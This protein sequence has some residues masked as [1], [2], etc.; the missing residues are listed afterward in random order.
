MNGFKCKITGDVG[1][2][3]LGKPA[4]PRRYVPDPL[5]SHSL[6]IILGRCGTDPHQEG[7]DIAHPGNCT[8]GAKQPIYWY[9]KEGNNVGTLE[10]L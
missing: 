9:Q 1:T 10:S 2:Q 3:T 4:V 8:V 7:A 5:R 6:T